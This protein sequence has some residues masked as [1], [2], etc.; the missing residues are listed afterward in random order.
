MGR[1]VRSPPMSPRGRRSAMI[2]RVG[3]HSREAPPGPRRARGHRALIQPRRFRR[4]GGGFE[5]HIKTAE[6]L[7]EGNN[8]RLRK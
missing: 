8:Q 4:A 6:L 1:L 2:R 3:R 5:H 7:L